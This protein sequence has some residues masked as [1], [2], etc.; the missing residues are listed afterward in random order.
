[1]STKIPDV[2]E[3]RLLSASVDYPLHRLAGKYMLD[4]M[5]DQQRMLLVSSSAGT[6][7][8]EQDQVVADLRSRMEQLS[9]AINVL[10]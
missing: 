2:K 8:P 1:M 7:D 4:D 9:C 5:C 10:S 3:R 6:S